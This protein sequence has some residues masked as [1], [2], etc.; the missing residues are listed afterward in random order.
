MTFL[1]NLFLLFQ[2]LKK[3]LFNYLN[4]KIIFL[5]NL[6]LSIKDISLKKILKKI[7]YCF[8][9]NKFKVH[10]NFSSFFFLKKLQFYQ[11][12]NFY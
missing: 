4:F 3:L 12:I 9:Q 1:F 8:V 11:K 6:E 2:N 10:L 7:L 5:H